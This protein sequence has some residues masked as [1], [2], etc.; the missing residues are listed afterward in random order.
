MA[1]LTVNTGSMFSGKSTLLIS[2]GEKHVK[3]G[4]KVLYIKP[5]LDNRYSEDEIVTHD[6]LKVK[7]LSI[8]VN[9]RLTDVINQREI[10]VV[11]ID[12]IQ[13]FNKR[14]VNSIWWLLSEGKKVYASGLDLNYL[15]DGFETTNEVM[16]I[17]DKVNK[18]KAVCESCGEDAVITGKRNFYETDGTSQII[19]LGAKE[20]YIPFCRKCWFKFMTS[21]GKHGD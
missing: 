11:L 1:T 13:F 9:S 7:A 12:E 16:A 21:G 8:E 2:Q 5:S 4:Q 14:I 19:E 17:A 3:A 6:G 20:T 18:L 15:G 10:D